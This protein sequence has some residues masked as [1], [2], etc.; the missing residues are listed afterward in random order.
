MALF[1]Q[2]QTRFTPDV[3]DAVTPSAA[4]KNTVQEAV[5]PAV[6]KGVYIDGF[7]TILGN[8]TKENTLLDWCVKH[9]FNA[10]SVYDLNTIMANGRYAQLAKFNKKAHAT[11]GIAQI[12]AVRGTAA[13]FTQNAQYDAG[14]TDL[15]E[16]FDVYNLENEWWNNGPA[17]DFGCYTGILQSLK[18]TAKA[19]NPPMISEAYIGWFLNPTGQDLYQAS[20]LVSNLDRILVHDYRKAPDFGYMQERLSYLGRAAQSQNRVMDVIVLFS[21]ESAFMFNYY[22]TK[23]QN[24]TFGDAYAAI[25]TQFNA[26]NFDGKA[27]I[28]LIGYQVFAYSFAKSARP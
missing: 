28:R 8:A 17:C 15:Q 16:R 22:S 25:V 24:K 7:A 21:A 9:G 12:A 14:R 1:S 5:T 4:R 6:Y 26:A 13:N 2:C 18:S 11:Y 20:T 3:P 10:I 27:N 19:A 23:G